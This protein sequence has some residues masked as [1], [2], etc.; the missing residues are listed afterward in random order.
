MTVDDTHFDSLINNTNHTSGSTGDCDIEMLG[1][2]G[3]NHD[4]VRTLL[5]TMP[6]P[7]SVPLER[8]ANQIFPIPKS[9][10]PRCQPLP[11]SSTNLT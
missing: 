3:L 1:G 10:F 7:V 6:Y 11:M 8:R 4:E 9:S 5:N 2:E